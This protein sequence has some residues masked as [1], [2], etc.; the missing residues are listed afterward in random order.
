VQ[1]VSLCRGGCRGVGFG[2][3]SVY[4]WLSVLVLVFVESGV[5]VAFALR[6]GLV[7]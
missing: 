2:V 5:F 7:C 6:F 4:V 3:I 1:L